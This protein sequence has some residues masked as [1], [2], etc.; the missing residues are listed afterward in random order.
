M[1][2]TPSRAAFL[3]SLLL[4]TTSLV[5]ADA[6]K[7]F[8]TGLLIEVNTIEAF[9]TDIKVA[10]GRQKSGV[11]GFADKRDKFNAT[12]VIN[13]DL[14]MRRFIVGGASSNSDVLAYEEGG[15]A[16]S[17]HAVAFTL[18]KQGW[19]PAGEWD[20]AEN[21]YTL[22]RLLEIIYSKTHPGQSQRLGAYQPSRRDGPLRKTNI[23]DQEV[24]EIQAVA[25][26]VSPGA[27]VNISGVVTGC[28]CED[29]PACTDQV[30][31]VAY[32]PDQSRGLQLSKISDHWTI[33]AVQQWWLD[34]DSLFARRLR[35]E[36][37]WK[38]FVAA[39]ETLQGR[40][41]QCSNTVT[42]VDTHS[43]RDRP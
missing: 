2:I 43:A 27:I 19:T 32:R 4:A 39:H 38:E 16:Y 26:T 29:G 33:G 28:P 23:S 18:G 11:D 25:A 1:L 31:V 21:P 22:R 10:L 20:L 13:S 14:P 3:A 9:P 12:D 42:S 37:S 8:D 30:W 34:R 5:A 41:P 17:I 6:G 7:F 36:L 24:R 15:R 40:L 35:G